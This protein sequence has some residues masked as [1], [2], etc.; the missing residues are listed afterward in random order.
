MPGNEDFTRA[1]PALTD[2]D[3]A[4]LEKLTVILMVS[5]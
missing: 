3:W 4:Q 1:V 5:S 2:E